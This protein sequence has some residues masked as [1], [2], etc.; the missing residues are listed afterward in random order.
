MFHWI[1][2]LAVL[3]STYTGL[4]GGFVEM[5]IHMISGYFILG[6][7][8][9]RLAWGFLGHH[10]SR[11]GEFV[12]GPS[13]TWRYVRKLIRSEKTEEPGHNPLGAISIVVMLILFLAQASTG[14]FANDDIMTEG[15]LTHLVSY[16]LSRTLTAYHKLNF[17]LILGIVCLHLCA[18]AFYALIRKQSIIKPMIT[19]TKYVAET[20]TAPA[21]K[22]RCVAATLLTILIIVLIISTLRFL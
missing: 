7:M 16:D 14:L 10:Y 12:K 6:L 5:D 1:L 15:P 22:S 21:H 18:V 9:F 4:T 17:W 2:V 13:S 20:H 3:V 19:G 11:F 8:L